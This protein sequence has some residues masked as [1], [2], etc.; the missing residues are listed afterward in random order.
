M[1]QKAATFPY[2]T[3]QLLL[4][5]ILARRLQD[6]D[7]Q[8]FFY[9]LRRVY[10]VE[11][12]SLLSTKIQRVMHMHLGHLSKMCLTKIE[13]VRSITCVC[14]DSR[15]LCKTFLKKFVVHIFMLLL[16]PFTSKF[17]NYSRLSKSW[18]KRKNSEVDDIFL[19]WEQVQ[20]CSKTHCASNNWPIL[21]QTVP[22]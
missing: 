21:S 1:K 16:A 15:L 8:L 2:R 7:A 22:K 12:H 3:R 10:C 18:N 19:R 14:T 11:V 5:V 17:V 4:L 6:K 20:T 13:A 9:R